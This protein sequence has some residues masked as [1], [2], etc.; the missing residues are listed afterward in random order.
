MRTNRDLCTLATAAAQAAGDVIRASRRDSAPLHTQ[1][2]G[3][4]DYVTAVDKAAEAAAVTLLRGE[5]PS[6]SVLAEEGGGERSARMWVIDPLDGTTN[7]LRG[8][9]EV[10]VSVALVEDGVPS[11]GVVT[12]P[13]TGGVWSAVA[14]HGAFD[15]AGRRLDIS[16][17]P[18]DGVAATGFPFRR[19][20]AR[21]RYVP[22]LTAAMETFEDLRRAGAASLDLAYSAAGVWDGFFELNLALWDIAAGSLLVREAGGVV[23]DWSGDQSAVFVSGDILAGSPAWHE[24]MLALVRAAA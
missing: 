2:K 8:Y 9:P 12:A 22:V 19:P 7:F 3:I 21:A 17:S 24:R 13:L 20:D 1:R 10:G 23:S 16:G 15:A 18:G 5:E 14:G 11:V 4:G 6:I